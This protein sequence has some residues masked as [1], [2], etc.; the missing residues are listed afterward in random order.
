MSEHEECDDPYCNQREEY[1]IE[2]ILTVKGTVMAHSEA[3]ADE[4]ATAVLLGLDASLPSSFS[5][6]WTERPQFQE[7]DYSLDSVS[8]RET[9]A[10]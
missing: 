3:E 6:D 4:L 1:E 8:M 9:R 5:D 10:L 7:A 2:F